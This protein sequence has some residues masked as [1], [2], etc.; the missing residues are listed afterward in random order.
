[1]TRA[2]GIQAQL[3]QFQIGDEIALPVPGSG[4]AITV[5]KPDC[6]TVQLKAGETRFSGADQPGVYAVTSTQP[7]L[8]FAVNLDPAESRTAPLAVEELERLGVPM[9]VREVELARQLEQKR[10]LHDAE[11]ESQ[12][13]MWR[14]LIAAALVVLLLENVAR[15]VAHPARRITRRG[16]DMIDRLLKKQLEPVAR[17]HRQWRRKSRPCR[18]LDGGS[19]VG[20]CLPVAALFHGVVVAARSARVDWRDGHRRRLGLAPQP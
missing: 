3:T 1:L 8:R 12:Q 19:L 6:S 16:P 15:R 10:R 5:Q 2:G 13:K 17:D 7:A 20:N 11:L 4:P 18:L 9:K 14:W